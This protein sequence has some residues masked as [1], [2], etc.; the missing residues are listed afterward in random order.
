[1]TLLVGASARLLCDAS[2]DPSPLVRW[3]RHD[4]EITED[5]DGQLE[6][7]QAGLL[8]MKNVTLQHD[9]WYECEAGNGVGPPQRRAVHVRVLGNSV[10]QC[11]HDGL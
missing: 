5:G 10:M 4:V 2:G 9:G 11:K 3:L 1:V 7:D 6:A 8:T